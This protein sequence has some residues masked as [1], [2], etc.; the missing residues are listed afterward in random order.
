MGFEYF[1]LEHSEKEYE[2]LLTK[3]MGRKIA[4]DEQTYAEEWL[5]FLTDCEDK[6][7]KTVNKKNYSYY[8]RNS[9]EHWDT[10]WFPKNDKTSSLLFIFQH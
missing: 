9:Y 2:Q 5:H 3:L 6:L 10:Y 1:E 7:E 8:Y 4:H